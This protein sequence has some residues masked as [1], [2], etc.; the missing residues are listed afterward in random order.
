[1]DHSWFEGDPALSRAFCRDAQQR[2]ERRHFP[3]SRLSLPIRKR[4]KLI[5]KAVMADDKKVTANGA[6]RATH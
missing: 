4:E 5:H 3:R 1:M 2:A 6:Q